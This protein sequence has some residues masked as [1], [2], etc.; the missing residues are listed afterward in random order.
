[1]LLYC[2]TGESMG[3]NGTSFQCLVILRWEYSP[4]LKWS[5][6]C[7]EMLSIPMLRCCWIRGNSNWLEDNEEGF[8]SCTWQPKNTILWD[9]AFWMVN[10]HRHKRQV[11]LQYLYNQW[12]P[13]A[14]RFG[15]IAN[16][17]F[18]SLFAGQGS[19]VGYSE[20]SKTRKHGCRTAFRWS[21]DVA[22]LGSIQGSDGSPMGWWGTCLGN[23]DGPLG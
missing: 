12:F 17:T 23:P 8:C 14:S 11:S 9:A 3:H 15:C 2:I 21:C 18:Q 19:S 4:Q 6:N 1:M 13:R 22:S 10:M 7:N 16:V 5:T 20:V